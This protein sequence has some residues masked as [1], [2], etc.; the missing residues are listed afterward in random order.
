MITVGKYRVKSYMN[1]KYEFSGIR[2]VD[3]ELTPVQWEISVVLAQSQ[4]KRVSKDSIIQNTELAYQRL[5]F[6]LE[7]NLSNVVVVSAD[8]ATGMAIASTVSNIMMVCPYEPYD[9]LIAE[10]LHHKFNILAKGNMVI[11]EITIKSNDTTSSFAFDCPDQ[12]YTLPMTVEEYIPAISL[13]K[14]PWWARDDGFCF[15]FLKPAA[16]ADKTNEEY[17]GI[18][19]DPMD[20]LAIAMDELFTDDKYQAPII[21]VD[22]W[23]PVII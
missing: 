11:G 5:Y 21:Q 23:K 19:T 22:T 14:L 18:I 2:I 6:W 13:H 3:T 7:T 4:K 12:E 1:M 17:F 15:E 10:L 9:E 20:Q 16:Y 8:N